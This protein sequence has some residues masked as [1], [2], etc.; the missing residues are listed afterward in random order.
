MG[1]ITATLKINGERLLEVHLRYAL[2][3]VMCIVPPPLVTP[4]PVAD[5]NEERLE[6]R[7]RLR[8]LNKIAM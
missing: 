3:N 2:Y 8:L 1:R 7:I 6:M 4:P 5:G